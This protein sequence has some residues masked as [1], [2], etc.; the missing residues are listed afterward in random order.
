MNNLKIQLYIFRSIAILFILTG[1]VAGTFYFS[2]SYGYSKGYTDGKAKGQK[3][4][5]KE[6]REPTT[7]D[8]K[9]AQLA[10]E[11]IIDIYDVSG[12]YKQLADLCE[13]KYQSA[14]N[15]DYNEAF[16]IK[17]QMTAIQAEIDSTM[18]KYGE[19]DETN[20]TLQ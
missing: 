7:E 11:A 1:V 15:G 2:K 14:L 6:G 4:G 17:G 3:E 20:A 8:V 10:K 5:Y 16:T 19:S 18:S 12:K 13:N 9:Q